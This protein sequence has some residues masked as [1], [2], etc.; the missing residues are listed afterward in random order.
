MIALDTNVLV[1]FLVEDDAEQT[2]RATKLLQDAAEEGS[3]CFVPNIVVCELV[4]V[5]SS[6]Y[7]VR[8]TEIARHLTDLLRARQLVFRSSDQIAAA[9]SAFRDGSGD[10]ADYLIR[11]EALAAECSAVATF[12]KMLLAE[13]GFRPV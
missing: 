12:D 13:D 10:F 8:R 2:K 9:L 11:E 7:K 6:A 1:R 5:L 4:W 3:P